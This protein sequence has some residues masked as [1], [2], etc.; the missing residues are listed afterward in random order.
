[1]FQI[2][3]ISDKEYFTIG[4]VSQITLVPK[5]TLRYW[6][7]EFKLLRPIRKSSGQRSYHKE[8]VELVFKIKDLLY[9]KRYT[10]EGA[11]K[12][13]IGDKRKRLTNLQTNLNL[14]LEYMPDSKFLK[15][16]KEELRHILKLLK[17]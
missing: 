2:P 7:S 11:K 5:H 3:P 17:K 4:E 15:D 9:N 12:H 8:E 10:I 13:L 16:I 1:M 14:D 6:E